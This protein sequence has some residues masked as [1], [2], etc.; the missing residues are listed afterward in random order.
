MAKLKSKL[1]IYELTG[2]E[3]L[4]LFA[5]DDVEVGQNAVLV[6]IDHDSRTEV[7]VEVRSGMT[8]E[9]TT[10]PGGLVRV[11]QTQQ[12]SPKPPGPGE[13]VSVVEDPAPAPETEPESEP[14]SNV[15]PEAAAN[16]AR[17]R[18]AEITGEERPALQTRKSKQRKSS[19]EIQPVPG[20]ILSGRNGS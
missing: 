8:I 20:E 7:T 5:A 17:Q 3:L 14:E 6:F 2:P 16:A 15:D 1:A 12:S 10:D 9:I 19:R 13:T 11:P 18:V 4:E